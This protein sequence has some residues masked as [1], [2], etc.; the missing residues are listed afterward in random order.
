MSTPAPNNLSDVV[1]VSA[2]ES[3]RVAPGVARDNDATR[4]GIDSLSPQV[5]HP[6]WCRRRA[7]LKGTRRGRRAV[8]Q[9]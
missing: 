8:H 3:R 6:R 7:G 5:R 2:I 9:S 1:S 4:D